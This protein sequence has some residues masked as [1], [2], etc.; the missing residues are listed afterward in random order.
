MIKGCIFNIQRYSLNDGVGIRTVVFF[1]GC[2]L[3]CPWCCNP[4]SLSFSPETMKKT[5]ICLN[6]A[7]CP[8]DPNLCPSGA[9]VEVGKYYTVDE[10]VDEVKR[11]S[12]FFDT[13]GG[14]ITFSGGEV[15]WQ[16][17]FVSIAL[18]KLHNQGFHTAIETC[19]NA[20]RE[21]LEAILPHVDEVLFDLKIL[22]RDIAFNTLG[23]NLEWILENFKYVA[24]SGKKLIARIP[25]IPSFTATE[26]NIKLIVEFLTPL[27]NVSE[28]H[29][30]PYHRYGIKKY[31]YLDMEYK[32]PTILPPSE[33]A[34]KAIAKKFEILNK[35]IIV[36][37]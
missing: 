24:N 33:E 5:D 4:E 27:E 37:G 17:Q 13:S 35:K 10:L 29:L 30:L 26:E 8:K 12:I 32:I 18:Q 11:D 19:G 15:L 22:D 6:R 31:E 23:A 21:H 36:G 3:H 34:V 14:G 2:K 9:F 28:V 1:K 16:H 7:S 20:P 25:L